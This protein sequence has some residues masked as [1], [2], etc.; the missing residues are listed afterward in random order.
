MTYE[1][2]DE[3]FNDVFDDFIFKLNK[4]FDLHLTRGNFGDY[5]YKIH[6]MVCDQIELDEDE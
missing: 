3:T 5:H 4:E 6:G 2:F 1:E